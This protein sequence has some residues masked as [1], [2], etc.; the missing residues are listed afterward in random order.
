MTKPKKNVDKP[1]SSEGKNVENVERV[2][3]AKSTVD[4]VVKSFGI[5][6]TACAALEGKTDN[7]TFALSIKNLSKKVAR[8]NNKASRNDVL[9]A[10]REGKTVVI[11][12]EPTE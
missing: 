1:S 4:S 11:Q 10:L 8:L 9:K 2:V 7:D 12:D 3:S 5:F 6:K